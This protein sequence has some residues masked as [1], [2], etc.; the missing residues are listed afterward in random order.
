MVSQHGGRVQLQDLAGRPTS[1]DRPPGRGGRAGVGRVTVPAA[2]M[3]P[4]S[5]SMTASGR[6]RGRT[7]LGD[8]RPRGD[9]RTASPERALFGLIPPH[10]LKL[11]PDPDP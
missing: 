10:P 8:P 3:P 4:A 2:D 7:P 11:V 6:A 9:W 5:Y 1:A